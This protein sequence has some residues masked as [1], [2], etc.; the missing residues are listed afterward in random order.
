MALSINEVIH[1]RLQHIP[2]SMSAALQPGAPQRLWYP[3]SHGWGRGGP[4]QGVHTGCR[5]HG[6]YAGNMP[7]LLMGPD[8]SVTRITVGVTRLSAEGKK[9]YEEALW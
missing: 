7:G 3:R 8:E 2:R 1:I 9:D 4:D 6:L 5:V